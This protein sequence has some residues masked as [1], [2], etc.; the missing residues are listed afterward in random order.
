MMSQRTLGIVILLVALLVQQTADNWG[1]WLQVKPNPAYWYESQVVK[2]TV[3]P[4]Q[5]HPFEFERWVYRYIPK[6]HIDGMQFADPEHPT[7]AI[8]MS[9]IHS[10]IKEY[11]HDPSLCSYGQ[12]IEETVLKTVSLEPT[13]VTATLTRLT[14]VDTGQVFYQLSWYQWGNNESRPTFWAWLPVG[15][16]WRLFNAETPQWHYFNLIYYDSESTITESLA[17]SRLK[18]FAIHL[19]QDGLTRPPLPAASPAH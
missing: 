5:G 2:E 15:L 14:V 9:M 7:G 3:G 16:S 1:S 19:L 11:L 10:T 6:A 4:W 8:E 18:N 13:P 12:G 17:T